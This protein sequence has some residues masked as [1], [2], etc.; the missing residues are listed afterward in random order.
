MHS[1][2]SL[3]TIPVVGVSL[4]KPHTSVTAVQRRVC[5]FACVTQHHLINL[6]SVR[7]RLCLDERKGL[8][9]DCSVVTK[10]NGTKVI[11]AAIDQSKAG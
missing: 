4:S 7:Y 3:L 11:R 2:K 10:E 6:L 5:M 1:I 9:L 8:L